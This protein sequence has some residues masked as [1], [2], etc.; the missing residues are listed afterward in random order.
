MRLPTEQE[1][2][3]A[4][5]VRHVCEEAG[6][7][8][9]LAIADGYAVERIKLLEVSLRE[10]MAKVEKDQRHGHGEFYTARELH[11]DLFARADALLGGPASPPTNYNDM[12]TEPIER[13]KPVEQY[14][15]TTPLL[16]MAAAYYI[17]PRDYRA[18]N[19][20]A[21]PIFGRA[22]DAAPTPARQGRMRDKL[23]AVLSNF[24]RLREWPRLRSGA[25]E[26]PHE[27]RN[28]PQRPHDRD[29]PDQ[30]GARGR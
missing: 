9:A 26:P 19:Y 22:I 10:F 14:A 21:L 25:H 7:S 2:V 24:A 4:A 17:H 8:A 20:R 28:Q 30:G 29:E 5:R 27:L 16:E 6:I 18:P 12:R 11:P 15:R 1:K 3:A 13:I 23:R